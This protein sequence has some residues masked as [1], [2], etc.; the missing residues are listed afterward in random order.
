MRVP[1]IRATF[2]ECSLDDGSDPSSPVYLVQSEVKCFNFDRVKTHCCKTGKSSA[3]SLYLSSSR[4]TVYFIEFKN[5][6][7]RNMA[8]S[9]P[10]KALD[11]LYV[12]SKLCGQDAVFCCDHRFVV[13]MSQEKNQ[14]DNPT[15]I[16]MRNSG[17][18]SHADSINDLEA[19]L[20]NDFELR[21]H[22]TEFMLA[23]HSFHIVLSSA[24]DEF[25]SESLL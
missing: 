2:K 13:V 18:F 24:F 6:S 22:D 12:H 4:E 20:K 11:S 1:S 25:V 14:L 17:Y 16:M 19:Q 3:D 15:I 23:Y 9:I 21:S 10:K 5:S 8:P 7:F